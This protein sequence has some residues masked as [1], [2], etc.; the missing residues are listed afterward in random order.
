M[1]DSMLVLI[2]MT[3]ARRNETAYAILEAISKRP[4]A[5][6]EIAERLK[7]GEANVGTTL[8]RLWTQG[9][10]KRER[11]EAGKV[12]IDKE[13]EVS[14]PLYV[15]RYSL[16]PRGRERL[17]WLDGWFEREGKSDEE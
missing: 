3:R 6:R 11:L 12:L 15:Y 16:T 4:S 10:V 2:Q 8:R 9:H 1:I 17:A 5:A 7:A 14:R 13:E